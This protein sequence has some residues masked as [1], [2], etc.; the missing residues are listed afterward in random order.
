GIRLDMAVLIGAFTVLLALAA[1]AFG[2]RVKDVA[3]VVGVRRNQLTGYGLV[4]GLNGSGDGQQALFTPQSVIN[5]LKRSGV[6]LNTNPAK[7]KVRTAAAVSLSATLPPF[8]RQGSRIDVQVSSMGDAHSL[9]GGVLVEAPLFGLDGQVY[10][11]AQGAVSLGGGYT[12][13]G[14]G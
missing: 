12:A 6:V 14:V 1:P 13:H 3:D 4:V 7:L 8:A 11:V 5:L 9:Q 2:A 10:A